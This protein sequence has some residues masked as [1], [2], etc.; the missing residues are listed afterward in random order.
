MAA[1]MT[2]IFLLGTRDRKARINAKFGFFEN[3]GK[4]P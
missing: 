2:G 4:T 1:V 3:I